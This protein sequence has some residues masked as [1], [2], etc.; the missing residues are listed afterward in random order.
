[1]AIAFIATA[2]DPNTFTPLADFQ[3]QTPES[4]SDIEVLHYSSQVDI[5]FIPSSAS[6]FQSSHATVYV[7]SKYFLL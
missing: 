4:L 1:M 3:S 2:P 5:A 7:T 6:P